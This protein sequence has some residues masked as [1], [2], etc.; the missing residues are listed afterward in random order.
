MQFEDILM[1]STRTF[2]WLGGSCV[3]PSDFHLSPHSKRGRVQACLLS[4]IS[5]SLTIISSIL[6]TVLM[7]KMDL[8]SM[9][10]IAMVF[11][12]C[13]TLTKLVSMIQSRSLIELLPKVFDHIKELR[14]LAKSRYAMDFRQFQAHFFQ[15]LIKIFGAWTMLPIRSIIMSTDLK[16]ILCDSFIHLLNRITICFVLF[17]LILLQHLISFHI[18]YIERKVSIGK[19]KL[20]SELQNELLFI[21][22]NHFKLYEISSV[23]N[24]AFGWSL[25][26]IFFQLLI[27]N[28]IAIAWFYSFPDCSDIYVTM[29]NQ[30]N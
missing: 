25:V 13:M 20:S 22:T 2:N 5:L 17:Y 14:T 7:L 6:Y 24:V 30:L 18:K 12:T 11:I 10:I 26:A 23:L 28:F 29:C 8:K 15:E 19:A 27:E 9:G 3:L 4:F 16:I 21:K 1:E